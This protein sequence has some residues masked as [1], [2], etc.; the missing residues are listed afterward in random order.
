MGNKTST[1]EKWAWGL[2]VLAAV[3]AIVGWSLF[4]QDRREP[5]SRNKCYGFTGNLYK[6]CN[7]LNGELCSARGEN[8]GSET[9]PECQCTT[10]Y[11]GE[12]CQNCAAGFTRDTKDKTKCVPESV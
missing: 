11:S 3:V 9:D 4:A 10:G 1:S 8:I 6:L 12:M 2:F 7:P 5:A